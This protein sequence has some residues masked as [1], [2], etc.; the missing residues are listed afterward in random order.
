V[1]DKAGEATTLNNIGKVY[2]DLDDKQQALKYYNQSLPLSRQ[3]D[4]K[5]GQA[6]TLSNIG[7]VYDDLGDKQQALKYY[8]QS[9]PLSRQVDDKAGEAT[10]VNNIGTVYDDLGDKQQARNYYNQSLPLWRKVGNK[11]G[12]ATTLNNIGKVYRDTKQLAEAIKNLE[13]SFKITLELRSGVGR[14]NRKTF[15]ESKKGAAIALIDLLISQNQPEQAFETA[16]LATIADLTD[17]SRLINAKVTKNPEAQKAIDLW[18]QK[19]QQL[20][21]LR[22][23]L[24]EK[25]SPELSQRVNQQQEQLNQSAE[26]IRNRFPEAADLF[27]TNSTDIAKL[28]ASISTG[29]TVIQPVLLTNAK[30]VPNT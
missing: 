11:V 10:T 5:A 15:L 16:N 2:D 14:E 3:V 4:D 18:N 12:E 8:N 22:K 9:L 28:Q 29:T 26:E 25:F 1:A 13:E 19:N 21:S 20:E 7:K 23:N 6:V 24:Q 27:E 17:Y 30:N